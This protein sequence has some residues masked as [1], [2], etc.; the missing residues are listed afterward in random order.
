MENFT[1]NSSYLNF[2]WT[3][4][5][6]NVSSIPSGSAELMLTFP[7]YNRQRN[8]VYGTVGTSKSGCTPVSP[9][10]ILEQ[11]RHT[12]ISQLLRSWRT[13]Q[14]NQSMQH[15]CILHILALKHQH[16]TLAAGGEGSK[17]VFLALKIGHDF[18]L[19]GWLA[20]ELK[21]NVKNEIYIKN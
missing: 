3:K 19:T 13:F 4:I 15:S 16:R 11:T 21:S 10:K 20:S 8:H 1:A 12:S 5:W 14:T 6:K 7:N 9:W 2:S 18:K 17:N